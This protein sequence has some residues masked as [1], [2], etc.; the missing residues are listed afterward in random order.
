MLLAI[1]MC[2]PVNFLT[3]DAAGGVPPAVLPL[4]AN[5]GSRSN[6]EG[7]S[8]SEWGRLGNGEG[9]GREEL[10]G[11]SRDILPRHPSFRA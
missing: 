9:A 5:G 3:S 7:E 6:A 2:M 11:A 1:G 8:K 4:L 10:E